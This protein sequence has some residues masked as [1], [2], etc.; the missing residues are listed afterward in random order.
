VALGVDVAQHLEAARRPLAGRKAEVARQA[1]DA[2]AGGNPAGALADRGQVI[3]GSV[4][5]PPTPGS[6]GKGERDGTDSGH[7]RQRREH[8]R[9][10]TE[11]NFPATSGP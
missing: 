2:T 4:L 1:V 11:T 6:G 3:G 7:Q 8:E 9:E 10:R 5:V